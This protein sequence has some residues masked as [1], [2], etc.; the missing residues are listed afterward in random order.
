[1][2]NVAMAEAILGCIRGTLTGTEVRRRFLRKHQWSLTSFY[3]ALNQL[4]DDLRVWRIVYGRQYLYRRRKPSDVGSPERIRQDSTKHRR[5]VRDLLMRYVRSSRFG[6][7]TPK[8]W[9]MLVDDYGSV[10]KR[11]FYRHLANLAHE[12][13]L[14]RSRRDPNM[15]YTYRNGEYN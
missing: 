6:V 13:L 1:M 14:S 12:G 11:T 8:L 2:R 10:N 15:E 7:D 4:V 3:N 9:R 5:V